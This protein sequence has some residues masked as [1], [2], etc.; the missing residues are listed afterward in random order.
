M[1]EI[2]VQECSTEF[3][4]SNCQGAIY[5][6][7][8]VSYGG[9]W[10]CHGAYMETSLLCRRFLKVHFQN[11]ADLCHSHVDGRRFSLTGFGRNRYRRE[12][13]LSR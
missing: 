13:K 5:S 7:Y 4:R 12:S 2:Q 6:A 1:L 3:S 11:G 10:V 9:K 8:V